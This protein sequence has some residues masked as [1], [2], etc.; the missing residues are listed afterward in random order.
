M[1]NETPKEPEEKVADTRQGG[2]LETKGASQAQP[3][4]T[5]DPNDTTQSPSDEGQA[6]SDNAE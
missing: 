6:A 3:P 2:N 4:R 5:A 1:N